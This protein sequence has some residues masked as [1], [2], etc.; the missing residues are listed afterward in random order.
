MRHLINVLAFGI[1]FGILCV[2]AGAFTSF[3]WSFVGRPPLVIRMAG[4]GYVSGGTMGTNIIIQC[5]IPV[6]DK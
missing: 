5:S 1:L 4:K 2:M 3:G 6:N